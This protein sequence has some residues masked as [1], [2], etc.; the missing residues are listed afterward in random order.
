MGNFSPEASRAAFPMSTLAEVTLPLV[1]YSV[2]D[3]RPLPVS[4]VTVPFVEKPLS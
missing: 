2:T 3:R 1:V 4:T